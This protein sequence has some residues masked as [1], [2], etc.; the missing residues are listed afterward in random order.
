M[1]YVST[2]LNCMSMGPLATGFKEWVYSSTDAVATI[3]AAGYFSDATRKGLAKG[4]VIH[5]VNPTATPAGYILVNVASVTAGAG[6]AQQIL[7]MPQT[8]F[9]SISS[10]NG[11]LAAGA[12]EGAQL[13]I[14]A[15]SGATALTTRTAAQLFAGVPGAYV[16]M[17]W[18][19]RA[20]NTNGGTL[21]FTGGTGVTITGTATVATAIWRDYQVQFTSATA[22]TMQNAG[23]GV[24]N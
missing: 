4:D 22:V 8:A 17:S 13:V 10:G 14:L 19:F 6:T 21:T 7:P 3:V 24:A 16:G 23:S 5:V 2:A 20:Y 9:S 12:M 1:A 18:L 11:T 15:T